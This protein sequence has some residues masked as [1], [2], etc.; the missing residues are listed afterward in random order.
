MDFE[1]E[2][3][4]GDLLASYRTRTRTSQGKLATC[5]GVHR[6]TIVKWEQQGILPKDRTR[7]E[8]I[9]RCLMLTEHQRDALLRAAL[10]D[11]SRIIWN[12]PSSHNP[13]FT[14]REQ[15]LEHL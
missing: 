1:E 9:A 13:F 3:S 12:L 7:I 10:L 5:L 8:E 11:I 6:S 14:G 4:F 2:R 15:E